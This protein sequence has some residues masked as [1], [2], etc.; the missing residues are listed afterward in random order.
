MACA[1]ASPSLAAGAT[2]P[3]T[4]ATTPVRTFDVEAYDIDGSKLLPTAE[5]EA[6]VYPFLGPGRTVQDIDNARGALEKAYRSHGYQSV[7]VELPVQTV[8][9]NIVRL[10]VIEAPVG[11]LRVTGSRYYSPE[12]IRHEASAFQEGEVPDITEAQKQITELNRLPDRRVTPILRAGVVPGT[13]DVDLKVSDTLPLHASVELSND[14][15]E[16]TAPL[17]VD[18]TIHYD[19]LWQAGHSATFTYVVAPQDPANSQVFAGSYLAPLWNTPVS[20]LVSGYDSNSNVAT[21]GG[22]SV[23]GKGYSVGFRVV[24]QLPRLGDWVDS[25]SA[26]FDYKDITQDVKVGSISTPAPVEYWPLNLGYNLQRQGP[27]FSTKASLS[28]TMGVPGLGSNTADFEYVRADARPNFI[29]ANLDFTQTETLRNGVVA[30]QRVTGQLADGPLVSSEQF[31]AGGLYSVRGYLQAEAIG[32]EGL[33]GSLELTSPTL[34]PRWAGVFDDLRLYLFNDGGAVWVL[35]P[36][37]EQAQFFAL[38]SAGVGLRLEL[39][40]H[41][42]GEVALAVPFISGPAT[43]A[44]T[45]RAT[46]TVKSEF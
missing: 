43:H 5:V 36:L 20:L 15:N 10:H 8:A 19:N 25:F 37:P 24:D 23:L 4:A 32:D 22:T 16:F 35:Q 3:D 2:P 13:V 21:I 46:F 39:L 44:Y 45:P 6:A 18:G 12:V 38:A 42:R 28:I 33:T 40:R 11:R 14:H 17:R 30:S 31:A 9:D 29:H 7:V 27:H 26:G 41:I 1:M 34:A